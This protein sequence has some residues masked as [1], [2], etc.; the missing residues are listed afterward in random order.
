MVDYVLPIEKM[1]EV[2]LGY[3]RH[4]YV[5]GAAASAPVEVKTPNHR[6][7]VRALLRA[8][9]KSDRDYFS[10]AV[11]RHRRDRRHVRAARKCGAE[12]PGRRSVSPGRPARDEA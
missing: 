8:R 7:T 4:W 6:D 12:P 2:R 10:P 9:I 5:N 1:A 3:V 11:R